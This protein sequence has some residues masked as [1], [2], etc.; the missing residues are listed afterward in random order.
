MT[1]LFWKGFAMA[2]KDKFP[3]QTL[4]FAFTPQI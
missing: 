2:V 4:C 3:V 1:Q